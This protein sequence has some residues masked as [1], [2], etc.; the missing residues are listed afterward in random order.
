[1][2]NALDGIVTPAEDGAGKSEG[3]MNDEDGPPTTSQA[4][5]EAFGGATWALYDLREL[6]KRM[7]QRV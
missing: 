5:V 4:R 3:C 6:W 7:G 1:M 2:H